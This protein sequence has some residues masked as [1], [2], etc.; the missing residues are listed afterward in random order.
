MGILN[1]TPDSFS[2]GS[3][4]LDLELAVDRALEME[5]EGASIIDIG[6]EST[7]PNADPVGLEEELRRVI[8]V[9]ERLAGRLSVPVSIDTHKAAVAREAVAAGAEIVND[10]SAFTF[11]PAMAG[12]VADSGAGA[13]LMHTRGGPREMQKDTE[14]RDI[15]SEVIAFLDGALARADRAGIGRS[16]LVVDPGIGFGK[17]VSGN[18]EIIRRLGEFARI[19]RPLLIGTSR[20]S[21]I[22]ALLD[23]DVDGRLMGTAATV[24]AAVLNGAS[25]IRVHDVAAMRDVAAVSLAI[26]NGIQESQ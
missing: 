11:D 15:V 16:R 7:R 19:G 3:R 18:L 12:V 20:K 14:Y 10:I 26:R 4:Y 21:F 13:V 9:I 2:D 6:G 1:V 22:G 25:V 5:G 24:A 8:P 23:R 17:S